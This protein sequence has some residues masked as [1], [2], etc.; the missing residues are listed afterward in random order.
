M[1]NPMGDGRRLINE[2][3]KMRG[4]I[5]KTHPKSYFVTFHMS[6]PAAGDYL[7][8]KQTAYRGKPVVVL[9]LTHIRKG[10][11]FAELVSKEDYEENPVV[12]NPNG[13]I[14]QEKES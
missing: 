7:S 8:E 12:F 6:S 4:G 10:W 9:Q 3:T 14:E 2:N 11:L 5:C 13:E 1:I